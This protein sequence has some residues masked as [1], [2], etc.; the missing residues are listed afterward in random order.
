MSGS[1]HQV[2]CPECGSVNTLRGK[3]MTLSLTCSVCNIYFSTPKW[4]TT[5]VEFSIQAVPALPVGSRGRFDN[6]LYEVMGFVVKEESKYHY[7]W[8]EYLLFNPYRGYAFLSEYNGHWNFI[9]PVEENPKSQASSI[10]FT[11]EGWEYRLYQKYG[12]NVIYAKGE[13]F[14]DVFDITSHA[15]NYEYIAPPYL[16]ALEKTKDSIVWCKGEYL[17][18]A[19]IAKAFSIPLDRLPGREGIG[20]TQPFQ[21]SFTDQSLVIVAVALLL[22]TFI[23][24]LVINNGAA[25]K[26]VYRADYSQSDM[27]DQ[28]MIVTPSFDL[29]DGTKSLEVYVRAPVDNNWFFGE[30]TLINETNGTEYNFTKEVEYYHGYEGGESWT[31]G[32]THGEAF[33]SQIPAGK[34]HLNIYPEFGPGY[35]TFSIAITRDVPM[36]VN[37]FIT[38]LALAIYPMFYFIKKHNREH[39]RWSDSDYS[40]Y[41]NE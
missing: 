10:T 41:G 16:Y 13:F 17:A 30:F 9:W 11:H 28:K 29:T 38:A 7:K 31:E 18:P 26:Q 8:R 22:V 25:D 40:P 23:F 34:Y 2:K 36:Q 21:S 37:F 3:A 19:D 4:N 27:N 1:E 24:Q 12:A 39:K 14:F 6:Y 32:S 15:M 35:Q 33:L 20:Y 5:V